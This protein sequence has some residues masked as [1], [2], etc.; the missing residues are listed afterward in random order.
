[1]IPQLDDIVDEANDAKGRY[2]KTDQ[3]AIS[4]ESN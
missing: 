2:R 4:R 1:L 3:H